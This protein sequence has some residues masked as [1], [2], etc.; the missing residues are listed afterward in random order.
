MEPS[1]TYL[2]FDHHDGTDHHSG[3]HDKRSSLETVTTVQSAQTNSATISIC[4]SPLRTP[5]ACGRGPVDHALTEVMIVW[6]VQGVPVGR[7]A[8]PSQPSPDQP[9]ASAGG[10][11]QPG[12][13]CCSYLPPA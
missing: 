9:W 12:T 6:M 2:Q 5:C 1:Q 11:E 3:H 10:Y 4:F 8:P 13:R 7:T